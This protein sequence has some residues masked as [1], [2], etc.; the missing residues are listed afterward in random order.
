[1]KLL[2]H[3]CCG[4]C[5]G[6]AVPAFRQLDPGME[7]VLFWENPNIHPFVEYRSRFISFLRA[8]EIL[9][10]PILSGEA[11]YGLERF[12]RAVGL[13]SGRERCAECYRLRLQAA[14]KAA[15]ANNI[16]AFTTTLLV[17]PYQHHEML[18][19][20]GQTVGKEAGVLFHYR[21]IRP[22]FP[23]TRVFARENS[24]YRQRY[25][26]CVFSEAERYTQDPKFSLPS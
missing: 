18:K 26:G 2:I 4:P 20:T 3:A 8:A 21:D 1:M 17:S 13:R 14:A 22:G 23:E 10:L 7:P 6:G 19:E 5:T 25:C 16:D 11:E 12:L 24:L 9:G 15:Q